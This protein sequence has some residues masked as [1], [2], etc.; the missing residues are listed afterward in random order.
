MGRPMFRT[1]LLP[2]SFGIMWQFLPKRRYALSNYMA[3]LSTRQKF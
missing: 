2:R 1:N 3:S